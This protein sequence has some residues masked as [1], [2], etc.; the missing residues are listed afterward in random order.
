LQEL[1]EV[2]VVVIHQLLAV[3][4]V[5]ETVEL[6]ATL[7]LQ[8]DPQILEAAVEVPMEMEQPQLEVLGL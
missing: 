4:A 2:V 3:L 5:V 8:L 7:A 6:E 1:E